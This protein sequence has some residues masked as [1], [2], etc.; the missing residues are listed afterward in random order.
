MKQV[1]RPVP[2][3]FGIYTMDLKRMAEFYIQVFGLTVTDEGQPA[4]FKHDLVF[5]SASK[6]QH[7]QLVLASGRPADAVFSN[8]MQI[9][10]MVP[11]IQ[12]LRDIWKKAEVLGAKNIRGINHGNT[13]SVYFSDPENNT[14]ES[15]IDM[16]FYVSQPYGE[17]LDLSKSDAEILRET[18]EKARQNP[19]FKLLP[20][21][22]ALFEAH[23]YVLPSLGGVKNSVI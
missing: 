19:S 20:E 6:D 1:T 14:V 7:H 16:P 12:Y 21:W 13:L 5:L 4:H 3:H 15:Y 23:Q 2:S 17:P 18:E 10:F 8:V 9:S 22:Q 11:S